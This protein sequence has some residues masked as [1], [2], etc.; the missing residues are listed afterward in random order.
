MGQK[1]YT[2]PSRLARPTGLKTIDILVPT[3][4]TTL[5]IDAETNQLLLAVSYAPEIIYLAHSVDKPI[6]S[7]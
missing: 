5:T 1:L 4:K 2:L 6:L 7:W 3:D